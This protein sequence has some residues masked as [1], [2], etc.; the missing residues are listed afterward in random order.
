MLIWALAVAGLHTL[1]LR[2]NL[3]EQASD[4]AR[5]A[6]VG[7]LTELIL[8]D[9]R[10]HTV[11]LYVR[12]GRRCLMITRLVLR[13]VSF[14]SACRPPPLQVPDLA[15]LTALRRLE[16]SYN[17]IKSLRPLTSLSGQYLSDL[18]VASNNVSSASCST[19]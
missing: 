11:R 13:H 9:N 15:P 3:L 10:L 2:Q 4:V 16:L 8:H 1:S 5:L 12:Y 19:D 7:R 17:G 14:S 18:Y 6:S